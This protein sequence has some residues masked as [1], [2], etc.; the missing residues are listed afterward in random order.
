MKKYQKDYKL[1]PYLQPN[2]KIKEKAEYTGKYYIAR[3]SE[4]ELRKIKRYSLTLTLCGMLAMAGAG[5]LN[6]NTGRVMYVALPYACLFFPVVFNLLGAVKFLTVGDKLEFA[7]YDKS[8]NRIRRSS[9]GQLVLSSIT[10][11]G[12]LCFFFFGEKTE[13]IA[14]EIV[15]LGSMVLVFLCGIILLKSRMTGSYTVKED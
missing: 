11:I 1:I 12:S 10:V 3:H 13:R 14:E 15:F 6:T 5:M 8:V 2:G 7:A 4:A 9:I